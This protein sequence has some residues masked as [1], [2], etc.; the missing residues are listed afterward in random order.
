MDNSAN[1]TLN[2]HFAFI[3]SRQRQND[4]STPFFFFPLQTQICE[5]PPR[6]REKVGKQHISSLMR[7]WRR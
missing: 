1:F 3:E 6:R 4:H 2:D 7:R 5:I